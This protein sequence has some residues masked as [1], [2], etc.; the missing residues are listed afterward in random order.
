MENRWMKM[1]PGSL[2]AKRIAA[3]MAACLLVIATS[4]APGF[5]QVQAA[6]AASVTS[7]A[8]E[9]VINACVFDVA[10]IHPI[11]DTDQRNMSIHVNFDDKGNFQATGITM[12]MLLSIAYGVDQARIGSGPEWLTGE[13]FNITA[14]MDAEEVARFGKLD[15]DTWKL[16]RRHAIKALLAERFGLKTHWDARPQQALVLEVA[17]GGPKL[18]E[19]PAAPDEKYTG[20]NHRPGTGISSSDRSM[21]VTRLGMDG[22]ADALG[23]MLHQYVQNATGLKGIYDFKLEWTP[24]EVRT[25]AGSTYEGKADAGAQADA[26]GIS[27]YT[28]L[29][30]QLGLKLT[31]RKISVQVLAIDSIEK[32]SE[33]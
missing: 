33:N 14:K 25:A 1:Q 9:T 19:S 7:P 26:S 3:A 23:Q 15:K 21:T 32:P 13:Q 18:T 6:A 29:E 12:K 28:A 8:N 5:A 16:A 20:P 17:K 11:K 30:E 10:S 27:I 2:G 4:V 31:S 22:L 24:D